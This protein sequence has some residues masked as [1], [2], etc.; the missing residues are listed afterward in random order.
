MVSN[1]SNSG[2][3]RFGFHLASQIEAEQLRRTGIVTMKAS[4]DQVHR[5]LAVDPK[6]LVFVENL[7]I[8][9]LDLMAEAL[10]ECARIMGIGGEMSWEVA[11][12]MAWKLGK[13]L[14]V[15]PTVTP[16]NGFLARAARVRKD[17]RSAYVGEIT[18]EQV[19]VDLGLIR[20]APRYLNRAGVGDLLAM[21]TALWDWKYA[22]EHYDERYEEPLMRDA[23]RLFSSVKSMVQPLAE[24]T[25]EGIRYLV[26][27][28]EKQMDLWREW[29]NSRP[30]EGSEHHL[31]A[32]LEFVSRAPLLHG[33]VVTMST[34]LVAKLQDQDWLDLMR[35]ADAIGI[36]W[37]P[38]SL[39]IGR[40]A[41]ERALA[42]VYDYVHE[43]GLPPGIL[44][45]L[46]LSKHEVSRL[47]AWLSGL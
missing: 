32:C 4:W 29:G 41:V 16:S 6:K 1:E 14:V 7:E 15:M 20:G 36:P 19:L 43:Q 24:V 2:T 3:V 11:K 46:P 30:L 40:E 18:P 23:G 9:T 31:A 17:G 42:C 8:A 25:E 28:F 35:L 27:A 38:S 12:Y 22:S 5:S 10:S 39:H 44:N 13:P 34:L 47:V 33:G 26:G 37:R 45:R 21:T